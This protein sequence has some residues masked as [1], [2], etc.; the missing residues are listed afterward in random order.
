MPNSMDCENENNINDFFS[1]IFLLKV[2][3]AETARTML[4][5]VQEICAKT[6]VLVSMVLMPIDAN[7]HQTLLETFASKM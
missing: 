4:M 6:G 3:K 2:S 1:N 7:A 5:I